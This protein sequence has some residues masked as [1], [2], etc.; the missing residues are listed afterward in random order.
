[1]PQL[2]PGDKAPDF[3]L[4]DQNGVRSS[5]SKS[6]KERKALRSF[7]FCPY[8]LTNTSSVQRSVSSVVGQPF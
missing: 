5:L 4:V 2:K 8:T 7:Y 1:M 3:T 6:V